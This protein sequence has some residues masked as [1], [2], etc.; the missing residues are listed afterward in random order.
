MPGILVY[1]LINME[2]IFN[3]VIVGIGGQ[4]QITLLKILAQAALLE[5][6]DIKTSELHGLSQKGGP[7]EVHFRFGKGVFSP[8]AKEGG[9]DLIIAIERQEALRACYYASREAKTIFLVNDFFLPIPNQ[10]PRTREEILKTLEKFSEK[11]IFVPASEICQKEFKAAI[12]AGVF[13]ISLASF[14]GLLPLKPISIKKAIRKI[15]KGKYWKLNL[16]IF[17]LARQKAKEFDF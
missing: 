16:N 7:V 6:L 13:L 8:L 10:R 9:A 1:L 17:E 5:N 12:T 4:G 2:K 14:K 3:G 11:A 15:I